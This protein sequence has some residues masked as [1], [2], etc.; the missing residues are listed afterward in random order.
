LAYQI[1]AYASSFFGLSQKP[2][3]GN[4]RRLTTKNYTKSKLI[5]IENWRL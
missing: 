4:N 1:F 2:I 3:I 5:L